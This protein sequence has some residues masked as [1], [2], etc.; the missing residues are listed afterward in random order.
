CV[1]HAASVQSEPESNSSVHS[2][3]NCITVSQIISVRM[4]VFFLC[5][6]D[7]PAGKSTATKHPHKPSSLLLKIPVPSLQKT[8]TPWQGRAL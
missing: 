5:Q 1:K 4:F 3:P 6:P 2:F 8:R 7:N